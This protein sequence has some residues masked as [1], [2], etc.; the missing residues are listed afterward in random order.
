MPRDIILVDLPGLGV[1]N[2][3]HVEFTKTYIQQKAKAFVVCMKPNSL[4][5]G[6]ELEFLEEISRTNPTILQRSFWI[7][8]QWDKLNDQQKQQEEENFSQKVEQYGF[9]VTRERFF[10]FSAL[11]HLLLACIVNGTIN[12]TRALKDHI[13]SLTRY[14]NDP[15]AINPDQAR[16]LLKGD[17]VK[18]FSDFCEALFNYL[19]EIAKGEFIEDARRELRQIIRN[20]IKLLKP[21]YEQQYSQDADLA[22]E[23]RVVE[24]NNRLNDFTAKLEDK[25]KHFV[26]EVRNS[27]N[28][29]FWGASDTQKVEAEI[30]SRVSSIDIQKL[31]SDLRTGTDIEGNLS[32]LPATFDKE[33]GCTL[34]LLLRN[35][36]VSAIESI[37][38][39]RLSKLC[40]ELKQVDI[41]YL[42]ESILE[43]LEDKLGDRDIT[44]RLNGLADSLFYKYGEELERIGLS[45]NECQGESL[46][47]RVD[48]ALKKYSDD[49]I[50]F[51]KNLVNDLGR[52][53][54]RSF[55]NHAE[56][57]EQELLQ[58]FDT[59]RD[60]ILVQ[61]ARKV[62]VSESVRLEEQKRNAVKSTY[63]LLV[64]L[65]NAL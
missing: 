21:L 25:V 3:R 23:F 19:N 65:N 60:I 18:P 20:S 49:L 24:A 5:E 15:A 12:Q 39:Q 32:R 26:L 56:Y 42:P 41:E 34:P 28:V 61:I 10:K 55:K 64:N 30:K 2:Q 1:V 13:T 38:I 4:L 27:K 16:N 35:S 58:T 31:Y 36:L 29:N 48:A 45:L 51:T 33:V 50:Q 11:N 59:Q 44:M 14:A 22:A 40:S 6:E 47:Q 7:I 37:F 63:S 53:T 52:Y 54:R 43:M 62:R 9:T 57:L 46:E 8:N 17:E